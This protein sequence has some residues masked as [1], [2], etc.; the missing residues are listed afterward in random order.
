MDAGKYLWDLSGGNWGI[1]TETVD[2]ADVAEPDNTT[3]ELVTNA[4]VGATNKIVPSWFS[5]THGGDY[6]ALGPIILRSSDAAIILNDIPSVINAV[7]SL[8]IRYGARFINTFTAGLGVEVY[9]TGIPNEAYVVTATM[10]Y[11]LI[12]V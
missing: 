3:L 11:Y 2:Q 4:T 7:P 1:A 6:A 8:F 5:L 9:V 12:P 10:G